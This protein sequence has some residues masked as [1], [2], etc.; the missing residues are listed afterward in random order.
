VSRTLDG[1]LA[2]AARAH[3]DRTALALPSLTGFRT[4]T[5]AELDAR[6]DRVAAGLLHA[7]PATGHAHR[8]ARPADPDFFALAFACSG[9]KAVPVLVDPGS[10]RTR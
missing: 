2:E 10:A 6:V 7:G 3:P 4:I 9:L 8:A 1:L 5:F